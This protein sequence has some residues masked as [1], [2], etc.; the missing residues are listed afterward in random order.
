MNIREISQND[1][2]SNLALDGL[3]ESAPILDDAQFYSSDG[4]AD[5]LKDALTGSDPAGKIT[6]SINE[7]NPESTHTRPETAYPK[8]LVSFTSKADA[9][10]EDRNI[11]PNTELAQITYQD[12]YRRGFVLQNMFFEGDSAADAEDFDGFRN[13]VTAG[14]IL[15]DGVVVPVGGDAVAADQQTA[16]ERLLQ[17]FASVRGGA[18]FAYMND[19]L[20]I[21]WLTVAK[22]LG[23]YS[24]SHDELGNQIERIGD[25]IIRGA[26]KDYAGADLLPFT[27][28]VPV[29]NSSSIFLAR[30]A[31]RMNLTA[32]TSAGVHGRFSEDATFL[33]NTVNFDI[34]LILQDPKA[35]VQSQ[36]WRLS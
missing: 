23:Y 25:T 26:G 32:L 4:N 2:I 31:E 19:S 20:R 29:A 34:T 18:Q 10:L 30:Y 16:I 36:G 17:H 1:P 5:T 28:T 6:R 13:L 3:L 33:K 14:N 7:A 12:A 8:K 22:K 24:Q 15:N 11:D 9:A 27:E 21:R 35:L